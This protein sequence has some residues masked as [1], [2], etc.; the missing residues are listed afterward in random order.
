MK[1]ERNDPP[2][3]APSPKDSISMAFTNYDMFADGQSTQ[4]IQFIAPCLV[5]WGVAPFQKV[6]NSSLVQYS[7][8]SYT[9]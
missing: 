3:T 7:L 1:I 2:A 8:Y 4:S 5:R 6:S 9:A